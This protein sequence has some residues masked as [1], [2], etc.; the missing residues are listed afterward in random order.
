ME[1]AQLSIYGTWGFTSVALPLPP[2]EDFR[3]VCLSDLRPQ[4]TP[5]SLVCSWGPGSHSTSFSPPQEASFSPVVL[6]SCSPHSMV[7]A[8]LLTRTV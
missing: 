5:G 3:P 1:G 4:D 2:L 8:A 6:G 7:P